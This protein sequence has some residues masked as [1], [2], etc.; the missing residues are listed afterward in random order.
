LYNFEKSLKTEWVSSRCVCVWYFREAL[1]AWKERDPLD[2]G[3]LLAA[4][5][6]TDAPLDGA[7]NAPASSVAAADTDGFRVGGGG[8]D[9]ARCFGMT[10][11]AGAM[12]A[13]GHFS[14]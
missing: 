10:Y 12:A 8:G 14:A 3:V 11:A 6:A 5:D 1:G 7:A 9:Y 4:T 2:L 13:S